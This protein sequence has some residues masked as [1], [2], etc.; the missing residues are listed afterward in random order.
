MK[1]YGLIGKKL[2]HSWSKKWFD[3]MFDNTGINDA[4]YCLY[5]MPNLE[6][7]PHW[8]AEEGLRGFNVTIPYKEEIIPLLDDMDEV[9]QAIGATNCVE[10][11]EGR[12]VGHNT[13][14]PAFEQTL[15]PLLRPWHT[16]ALILGTGGASKAVAFTF[17]RLGIDYAFVSRSPQGRPNIIGYAE[18]C[19]QVPDTFLIVNCTPV[20]MY[21]N[22][23]ASP[24]PTNQ[25]FTSRHLCYDLIYNPAQTRFLQSAKVCGAA[26]AGGLAMLERQAQLSWNIWK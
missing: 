14:A 16:R 8:V 13:D 23:E 19:R 6:G 18:A 3:T 9:V 10:V 15:R 4:Q 5:E 24:W 20:G 11:T 25:P 26:W 2:G 1:K 12:L 7:L 17:R 22:T 21:P